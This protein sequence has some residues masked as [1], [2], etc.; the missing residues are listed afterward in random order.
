[1]IEL[2]W[3]PLWRR[4][5]SPS[6]GRNFSRRDGKI[7]R[8]GYGLASNHAFLDGNKRI[9]AMMTQLLLRW[10]GY[11]LMLQPGELSDMFISLAAGTADEQA[12]LGWVPGTSPLKIFH[13]AVRNFP[14]IPAPRRFLYGFAFLR[15]AHRLP[16]P[17]KAWPLRLAHR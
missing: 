5:F 1:M 14:P 6:A 8:L 4:P 17:G 16:Q 15:K 3:R 12:L 7:A 13:N 9:G 11:P 10:N 2:V